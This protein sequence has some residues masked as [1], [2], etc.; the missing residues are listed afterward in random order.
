MEKQGLQHGPHL[1]RTPVN[2]DHTHTRTRTHTRTHAHTHGYSGV[3]ARIH[4]DSTIQNSKYISQ[5]IILQS[6]CEQWPESQT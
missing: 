1:D 2:L 3:N 5:Y 6:T 4:I